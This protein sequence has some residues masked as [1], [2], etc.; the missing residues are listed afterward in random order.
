MFV[1]WD[2]LQVIG[3]VE[4]MDYFGVISGQNVLF[5]KLDVFCYLMLDGY[6]LGL[7]GKE[8]NVYIIVG[9]ENCYESY[10]LEEGC[11]KL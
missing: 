10:Q 3:F 1:W 4:M 5:D 6:C 2:Y 7:G 9:I 8:F 11:W